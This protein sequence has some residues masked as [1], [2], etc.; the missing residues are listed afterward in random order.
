MSNLIAGFLLLNSSMQVSDGF[1]LN[2]KGSEVGS[3]ESEEDGVA[4]R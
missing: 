1:R 2:S 3:G 4:E